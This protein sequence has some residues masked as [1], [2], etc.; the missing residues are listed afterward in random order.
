M[1]VLSSEARA[2]GSI[3][4]TDEGYFLRDDGSATGVFLKVPSR[5]KIPVAGGDLLRA[6][7]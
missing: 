3:S 6:G 7:R 2:A 1:S 4:R 5:R